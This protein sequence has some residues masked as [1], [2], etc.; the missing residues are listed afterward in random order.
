MDTAST[1]ASRDPKKLS[2]LTSEGVF[3]GIYARGAAG[4]AVSG[5]AWL[6]AMLDVEA[7]VARACAQEEMMSRDAADAIAAAC[8]AGQFDLRAIAQEAAAHASPVVP[9][10]RALRQHVGGE[11]APLVHLG[12][13]SQDILDTAAALVSSRA[14]ASVLDDARAAGRAAATLA[15]RHRG[16]PMSGRTLLQQAL[17]V[18]FGLRA[19]GWLVGIA[20][21]RARLVEVRQR[22]L[23]V[24]MGGPVGA[25]APRVA[26]AVAAELGLAEPVVPWHTIRVRMAALAGALAV[27]TGVLAKI[28]R[29]VTLLAQNEVGEV[30]EGGRHQGGSTAM[31]HKRN[32]VAA[33]SVLACTR[34]VPGLVATI[35]SS[36]EQ[37]HER[38][39]GGWQAEWGTLSSLLALTGSAASWGRELLEH[40]EVDGERMR[41][42]LARLADAGVAEAGDPEDHLGAAS[43][44]IDRAL[45]AARV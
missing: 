28:A 42:N 32:P 7:A 34:R 25:R 27:L 30:R 14:L 26:S 1:S 31:G 17:P 19:A 29:D 35:L 39:A 20:D 22:E 21:A 16:T 8:V 5:E 4:D 37:E 24:Q 13:T 40:L 41:E 6:Q 10:V 43:E 38:A 23:A 2:S 9:L 44:L 11:L 18:S 33:V 12:A 36:M 15:E 45:A 3:S